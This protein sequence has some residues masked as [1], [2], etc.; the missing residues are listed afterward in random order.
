MLCA[1]LPATTLGLPAAA[2]PSDNPLSVS[3]AERLALADHMHRM[4][5]ISEVHAHTHSHA[6]THLHLHPG[7]MDV[8][9]SLPPSPSFFFPYSSPWP[10]SPSPPLLM[11]YTSSGTAL[12]SPKV[13]SALCVTY[14]TTITTA[15]ATTA[16]ISIPLPLLPLLLPLLPLLPLQSPA[17]LHLL[18][19][20]AYSH[21]F[22]HYTAVSLA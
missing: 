18:E 15:T 17:L 5:L 20:S 19:Y 22:K 11:A 4:Q 3:T 21:G 13:L 1:G 8:G 16:T 7:G 2:T 10:L 12:I 6:H 14:A 9:S